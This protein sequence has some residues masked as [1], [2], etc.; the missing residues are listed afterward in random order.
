MYRRLNNNLAL[1]TRKANDLTNRA[2]RTG[3]PRTVAAAVKANKNLIKLAN[4][5]SNN[6]NNRPPLRPRF[7]IRNRKPNNSNAAKLA[8]LF[9]MPRIAP[10]PR[11]PARNRGN[12]KGAVRYNYM[13]GMMVPSFPTINIKPKQLLNL[14]KPMR[15][16]PPPPSR[17]R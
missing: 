10:P 11:A 16:A 1:A 4:N 7:T 3:H 8:T 6:N 2:L 17:R 13:R 5:N 12:L 9:G 15:I 14:Y